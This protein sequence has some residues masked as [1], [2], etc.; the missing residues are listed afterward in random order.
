MPDLG[1]IVKKALYLGIGIASYA[2][3][4]AGV[5]LAQLRT[6]AQKL[7]DEMVARGEMNAEEARKFVDEMIAK[8]QQPQVDETTAEKPSEPRRIEILEDDE[9][10]TK[11]EATPNNVE[12]M[13]KQVQALQDELRRLQRE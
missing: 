2:G 7:A 11:Q 3:E 1:N 5:T 8:A 6:Q 13:R 12:E 10:P 4:K 9:E